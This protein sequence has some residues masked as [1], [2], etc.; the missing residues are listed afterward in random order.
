MFLAVVSLARHPCVRW[1][2]ACAVPRRAQIYNALD[3]HM[4]LLKRNGAAALFWPQ[5]PCFPNLFWFVPT[6]AAPL[7]TGS[8]HAPALPDFLL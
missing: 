2:P 3:L 7:H 8:A 6:S 1:V 5:S 4:L